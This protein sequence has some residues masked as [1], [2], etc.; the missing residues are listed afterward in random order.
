LV[1]A[2]AA[3]MPARAAGKGTHY[4]SD[5]RRIICFFLRKF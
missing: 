1:I 5:L 3:A 4:S 2:F